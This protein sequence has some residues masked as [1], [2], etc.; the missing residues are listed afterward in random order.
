MLYSI[1]YPF[2]GVWSR[3]EGLDGLLVGRLGKMPGLPVDTGPYDVWIQAVSVG[4]VAVAEA[5]VAAL[6]KRAPYLKIA[7]SSTTPAGLARAMSFLSHRCLVIPYPLD[8][9]RAVHRVAVAIRPKVY[10][11][12]ETELWPNMINAVRETGSRV[13]LINGR[14]STRSFGRYK[15]IRWL[16]G[17]LLREFS[18]VCA[19][20]E[21]HGRRLIELGAPETLVEVTGNAKFEGLI[22]RPDNERAEAL[23]CRMGIDA[24][25]HV[26]VAGSLRGDE[27]GLVIEAYRLLLSSF[28]GL[29]LFL[30]P[31]HIRKVSSIA[32]RLEAAGLPFQLWSRLEMGERRTSQVVVVDVV[33]PLFD[34]YGIA[35]VVFVGGSLV[36]KGGQNI[37][38]P[39]AWALPVIYGPYM[40]NFEEA[41]AALD[42]GGGF[43]VRDVAGLVSIVESLLRTPAF[44]KQVG[45]AAR[46]A[47]IG[48][49]GNAASRQADVI[50][51]LLN[52]AG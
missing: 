25:A 36:P 28:S 27:D 29:M 51:E 49:S 52:P 33:G 19:I 18:R 17:G 5:I 35:T 45:L 14:I 42:A 13:V 3:L 16:I 32:S 20:S 7:V 2:L 40:D 37:M 10:A 24:S 31:R 26:F 15:K 47:L 9:P 38:E 46:D 34:I 11:P 44:R 22:S 1:A 41:K 8:F 39:A 50:L 48:L 4:E 6:D 21:V 23:R 30:I 43:E 12:I